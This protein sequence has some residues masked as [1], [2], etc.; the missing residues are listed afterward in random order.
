MATYQSKEWEDFHAHTHARQS[1]ESLHEGF[2]D[3]GTE[4]MELSG[5]RRV[6]GLAAAQLFITILLINYNLRKIAGFL[7][8]KEH[9]ITAPENP[10]MRRRGLDQV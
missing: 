6:R 1:I 10:I 4:Q 5:R 3:P 9:S 8:D 2:K 7:Y